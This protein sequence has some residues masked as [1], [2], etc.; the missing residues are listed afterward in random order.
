MALVI[1]SWLRS[2][3]KV[4]TCLSIPV[5]SQQPIPPTQN[6]F[7]TIIIIVPGLGFLFAGVPRLL[8]NRSIL[9][10]FCFEMPSY[11]IE[12]NQL[13]CTCLWRKMEL[14]HTKKARHLYSDFF[15]R[16]TIHTDSDLPKFKSITFWTTINRGHGFRYTVRYIFRR[17]Q[18][19][20]STTDG[21][22]IKCPP[23]ATSDYSIPNRQ[24]HRRKGG[25]GIDADI[26]ITSIPVLLLL[27]T[28]L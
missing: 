9:G 22:G 23:A 27:R 20:N 3:V 13:V 19:H 2:R 8:P 26:K 6:S 10:G 25:K 15:S 17:I 24:L 1:S 14:T 12:Q 11:C 18:F 16:K 7:P 5:L 28:P 4:S 21:R